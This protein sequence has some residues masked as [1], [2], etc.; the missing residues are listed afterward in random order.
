M[1]STEVDH[2]DIGEA[3][4][5]EDYGAVSHVT[6]TQAEISLE[7]KIKSLNLNFTSAVPCGHNCSE[8]ATVFSID[9]LSFSQ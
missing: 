2:S 9:F 1:V 6:V 8:L 4:D 7:N 3:G 5:T